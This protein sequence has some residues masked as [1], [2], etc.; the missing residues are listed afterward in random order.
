MLVICN[1]RRNCLDKKCTCKEPHEHTE[2]KYKFDEHGCEH[3]SHKD[4]Q[5]HTYMH[6]AYK[7]KG[8]TLWMTKN[9]NM[10]ILSSKEISE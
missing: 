1:G 9:E 5:L 2:C 3:D 8:K 6:V 4:G 10:E 7:G